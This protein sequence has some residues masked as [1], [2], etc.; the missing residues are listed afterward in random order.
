MPSRSL[1]D[2]IVSIDLDIA[3]PDAD[4][5]TPQIGLDD[6]AAYQPYRLVI[7]GEKSSL[8]PV[9]DPIADRYGADL[10]LP[11]GEISRHADL[12]DG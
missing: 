2:R 9:L 3:I 7:V 8:R 6:F 11:T 10:Y 4:D 5:L 1:R 12:P